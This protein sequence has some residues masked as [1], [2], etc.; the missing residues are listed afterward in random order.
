L[1]ESLAVGQICDLFQGNGLGYGVALDETRVEAKGGNKA[2]RI[3][4]V[5]KI[6]LRDSDF[7]FPCFSFEIRNTAKCPRHE[8]DENDRVTANSSSITS[9]KLSSGINIKFTLC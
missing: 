1:E 5:M 4:A 3:A 6:L 8:G 9:V 7:S 2:V